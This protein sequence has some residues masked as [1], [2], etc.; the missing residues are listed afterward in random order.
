MTK[1]I[2]EEAYAIDPEKQGKLIHQE[3]AAWSDQQLLDELRTLP[4]MPDEDDEAW[5]L[6]RT[7]YYAEIYLAQL[8]QAQER[9]LEATVPY[10]FAQAS[11][12]DPGEILRG[13]FK[14]GMYWIL[15]ED[16]EKLVHYA[17]NAYHSDR[18]GTRYWAVHQLM[19]CSNNILA[20]QVLEKALIDPEDRIK[21]VAEWGLSR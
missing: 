15:N 18:R 10:F 12:G 1:T 16:E 20:R 7:W 5:N 11:Y 8:N 17:I 13:P 6:D 21:Q 19:V 9:K 14:S 3:K 2:S 4:P